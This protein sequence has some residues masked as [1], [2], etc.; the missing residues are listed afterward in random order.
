MLVKFIVLENISRKYRIN[1]IN[2]VERQ[3][4]Q[5]KSNE[6]DNVVKSE[7]EEGFLVKHKDATK[8]EGVQDN[9]KIKVPD[10]RFIDM[11]FDSVKDL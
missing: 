2:D 9:N 1:Q 7:E 3:V 11:N 8:Y 5:N 10:E 4:K 6:S